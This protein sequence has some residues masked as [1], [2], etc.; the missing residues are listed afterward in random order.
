MMIIRGV[1]LYPSHIEQIA[2][3]CRRRRTALAADPRAAPA[4]WTSSRSSASRARS[5][6]TAMA[7]GKRSKEISKKAPASG[8]CVSVLDPGACPAARARPSGWS[9]AVTSARFVQRGVRAQRRLADVTRRHPNAR[10]NTREKCAA[11]QNPQ[12][13]AMSVTEPPFGRRRSSRHRARRSVRTQPGHRR[14]DVLEQRVQRAH[15][16]RIR[17]RDR[18]R[19]ELGILQVGPRVSPDLRPHRLARGGAAGGHGRLD[20]R[21]QQLERG[22]RR[23]RTR[24]RL[25]AWAARARA[26]S[27][28]AR[29]A[30][31]ARCP[32]AAGVPAARPAAGTPRARGRAGTAA[33]ACGR[34]RRSRRRSAAARPTA[35]RRPATATAR[36]RPR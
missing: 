8:S 31:P 21:A 32:R 35:P 5:T 1:N 9:T 7:C 27:C 17:A 34:P 36:E 6:A 24:Q 18:R 23:R 10:L 2:H 16:D 3:G 4:R 26:R 20:R 29:A 25:R 14:V 28:S 13:N 22:V 11:S 33:C 30:A 15:R 19:P 12:R